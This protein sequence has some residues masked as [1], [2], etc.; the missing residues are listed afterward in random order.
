MGADE[1]IRE[2]GGFNAASAPVVPEGLS[3]QE[4]GFA[5]DIGHA[6]SA[7][8]DRSLEI[9]NAIESYGNLGVDDR[10]D[11]ELVIAGV[12]FE[13]RLGPVGPPGIAREQV[14]DYV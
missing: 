6:K 8:V 4:Q 9:L 2:R 5:R 10:I 11:A 3:R 1:K 7:P 12:C 14:E 13:R